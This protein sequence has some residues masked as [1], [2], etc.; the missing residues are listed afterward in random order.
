SLWRRLERRSQLS[1][2]ESLSG[3]LRA[4]LEGLSNRLE[5]WQP[6]SRV[7]VTD[8]GHS[9]STRALFGGPELQGWRDRGPRRGISAALGSS[10][11]VERNGAGRGVRRHDQPPLL[12]R[13]GG[14]VSFCESRKR[15]CRGGSVWREDPARQAEPL[16]PSCPAE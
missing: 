3:G 5:D 16:R 15:K 9:G 6:V 12:G 1:Q 2:A 10:R 7:L 11:H 13:G 8:R 4:H 14:A